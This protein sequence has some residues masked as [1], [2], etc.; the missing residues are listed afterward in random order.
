MYFTL[1]HREP[2]LTQPFL[3]VSHIQHPTGFLTAVLQTTARKLSLD[4]D[5]QPFMGLLDYHVRRGRDIP[6]E[7]ETESVCESLVRKGTLNSLNKIPSQF[8]K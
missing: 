4:S 8:K 6:R 7:R 5:R 3:A 1:T 2:S